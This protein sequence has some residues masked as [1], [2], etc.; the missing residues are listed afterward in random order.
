MNA[1]RWCRWLGLLPIAVAVA[2]CM[3]GEGAELE[4]QGQFHRAY[5]YYVKSAE[6][7]SNGGA[8]AAGIRRTAPLAAAHWQREAY[9]AAE[10]G[11]WDR[12]AQCH[13][14][15]L[16]IKPDELSSILSLRSIARHHPEA[17]AL[18]GI[19]PTPTSPLRVAP[20]PAPLAPEPPRPGPAVPEPAPAPVAPAPPMPV[21]SP[22]EPAPPAPRPVVPEP[23][24]PRPSR[25]QVGEP[26]V[27][28]RPQPQ[29]PR[30]RPARPPKPTPPPVDPFKQKPTVRRER[31]ASRGEFI[32]IVRLSREDR[33][34]PK[35]KPLADGLLAK[36]KDT[37]P[38]PLDV[39]LEIELAGRRIAK[40]EDL[41][42]DSVIRVVGRSGRR[43]EIVVG[44]IYDANETVTLG[45]R[46]PPGSGPRRSDDASGSDGVH[47]TPPPID[48]F[49]Q[50]PVA[51]WRRGARHGPFAA[52]LRLS[53]KDRRYTDE[54]RLADGLSVKLKDVDDDPAEA[55]IEIHLLSKELDT[56]D[57][58]RPDDV[59]ALYGRSGR[60]YE[61]VVVHVSDD[62]DSVVFGFRVPDRPEPP[63]RTDR[64]EPDGS[65]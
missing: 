17:V 26:H 10:A 4:R 38:D 50:E 15:V 62:T 31:G 56:L 52:T 34:Y 1:I 61:L 39:D 19:E 30:P 5:E 13:R 42:V 55:E 37:D 11:L 3:T 25:T 59:I 63:D 47:V 48:P 32:A 27:A 6:V 35:E 33:R 29:R 58:L 9:Q 54:G 24:P 41:T 22:P 23:S 60:R 57:E 2:G 51:R 44:H 8:S 20:R 21:P 16:A 40:L 36:V 46:R 7:G 49:T 18:A 14:K 45:L 53:R 12:A 64:P 43:Y 65:R 28:P